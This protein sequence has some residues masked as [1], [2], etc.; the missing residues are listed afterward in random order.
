M[1]TGSVN[2]VTEVAHGRRILVD[3]SSDGNPSVHNSSYENS[4]DNQVP[5]YENGIVQQQHEKS[6]SS[7]NPMTERMVADIYTGEVPD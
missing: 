7:L 1:N 3:D 4:P 5:E 2:H 6:E